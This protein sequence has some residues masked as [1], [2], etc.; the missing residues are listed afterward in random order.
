MNNENREAAI[1]AIRTCRTLE[2]L[3]KMLVRFDLTDS[4]EII[5]YLNECMYSPEIFRCP[6]G[7]TSLDEDLD[8]TKQI[9]LAGTWRVSELYEHMRGS[10]KNTGI[11]HA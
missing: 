10:K 5:D 7:E 1:A 4:Q 9:F 6:E 2:S 11:V 8:M 3:D